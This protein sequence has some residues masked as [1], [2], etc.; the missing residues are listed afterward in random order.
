MAGLLPE[1][2]VAFDHLDAGGLQRLN[3]DPIARITTFISAEITNPHFTSTGSA[4]RYPRQRA[5]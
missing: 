1:R 4:R 2:P 5:L 3:H